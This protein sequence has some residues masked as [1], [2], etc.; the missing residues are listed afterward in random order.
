MP[1]LDGPDCA[2]YQIDA[3]PI[4]WATLDAACWWIAWKATQSTQY[5]DPTFAGASSEA[6]QR[7][8]EQRGWYH[9]LSSTKDVAAQAQHYLDTIGPLLA[10]EFAM[11]DAEEA[12][13]TEGKCLAWCEAVEAVTHRPVVIYSGL[14]VA[15][16]TIWKS[17]ALRTSKYG[18]RP[19]IVAAYVSEANLI[20][21]MIAT[22]ALPNF[23][24]QAWQWSSNGPVP[25]IVGRCDQDQIDDRPAFD[26]ACGIVAPPI[27]DDMTLNYYVT[28]GA[29][30]KF[31]GT[32]ALLRWTGPGD[33]KIEAAIATQLSVGNLVRVDLA[34]VWAFND[35]FLDGPLPTGDSLHTWTGDEFANTAEILARPTEI[36]DAVA[37]AEI[38]ELAV[39]LEHTQAV[40]RAV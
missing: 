15:G 25:G 38:N 26:V 20:A 40:L 5:V 21:R 28:A 39:E 29:N 24:R 1:R 22:G 36:K 37:R 11:L 7:G 16:G 19:F 12:G 27:G 35:S 3:G 9:W 34:G 10:G 2:H 13:I 30:A 17:P 6:R 18:P 14:Y 8:F 4:D 33:T 32:P 31:I 23:P